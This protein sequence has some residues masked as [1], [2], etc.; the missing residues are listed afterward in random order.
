MCREHAPVKYGIMESKLSIILICFHS[1]IVLDTNVRVW[2]ECG[3]VE[4]LSTP[5]L[6]QESYLR[7]TT[8]T[9][10]R[11]KMYNK[12]QHL[13]WIFELRVN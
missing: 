3:T 8:G 6:I 5:V 11:N 13:A 7:P 10:Y 12:K 2:Y 9:K 1:V 4:R